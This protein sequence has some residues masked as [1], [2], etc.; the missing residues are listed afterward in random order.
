VGRPGPAMAPYGRDLGGPL[1][2]QE[3]AALVAYFRHLGGIATPVAAPAAPPG[4]PARGAP[5]YAQHCQSCH[6]DGVT[7]GTAVQLANPTLQALAS[8]GYLRYAIVFGRPGTPMEAFSNRLDGGQVADVIAFLRSWGKP[9]VPP[10]EPPVVVPAGPVVINPKG[11]APTFNARED[12]FV[13]AAEVAAALAKKQRLVIIDARPPSDWAMLH[14]PGAISVPHYDTS[15]L[16]RVPNDGTWV[17]AYCACPHHASGEVVDE[18]KR[19]GYKH[20]AILDEGILFWQRQGYPTTG[21]GNGVVPGVAPAVKPGMAPAQ[22][23]T[24]GAAPT[25]APGH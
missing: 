11:K 15:S 12:R 16:D 25:P 7:H 8:D 5:L 9:V 14:I 23:V 20:A 17:I 13:P 24:P 4:D 19:R 2:G 1:G 10:P 6:G 21:T 22:A 3:I 18:L